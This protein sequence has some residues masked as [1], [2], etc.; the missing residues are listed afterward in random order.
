[1]DLIIQLL[2]SNLAKW[3]YSVLR[4]VA[5]TPAIAALVAWMV[6]EGLI[7][8]AKLE[9]LMQSGATWLAVF[10]LAAVAALWSSVILP[11]LKRKTAP[12][13]EPVPTPQG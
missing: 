1:M 7:T 8:T 9:A 12:K 11:W 6:K 2:K 10:L 4:K 3:I 13:V 5:V